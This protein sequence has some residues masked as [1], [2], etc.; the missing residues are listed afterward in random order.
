MVGWSGGPQHTCRS[1]R[2]VRARSEVVLD[3]AQLLYVTALVQSIVDDIVVGTAAKEAG[4]KI[5]AADRMRFKKWM[6]LRYSSEE[7]VMME[8]PSKAELS[9]KVSKRN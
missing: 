7:D 9:A 5:G 4:L 3:D 6:E 8:T 1:S 2:W